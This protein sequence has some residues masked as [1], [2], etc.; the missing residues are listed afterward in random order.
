MICAG[1]EKGMD[2]CKGDSGG[3]FAVQDP[4]DK[5]KFYIAGLVSWGPQ[6]GTY[7]LYTRVQN[8]VDWIKKTMQENSTPRGQFLPEA[9]KR[10]GWAHQ[11][12]TLIFHRPRGLNSKADLRPEGKHDV[13]TR[14][15]LIEGPEEL[16]GITTGSLWDDYIVNQAA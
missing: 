11:E 6:C 9:K 2:S 8:Y 7:G 5:T 4:N 15:T 1:G 13:V 12:W 14:G 16:K 3:A 10:F